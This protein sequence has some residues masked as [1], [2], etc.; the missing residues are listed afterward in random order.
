MF[1]WKDG[2]AEEFKNVTWLTASNVQHA[3][4]F[5]GVIAHVYQNDR[6]WSASIHWRLL[7]FWQSIG[8]ARRKG[9]RAEARNAVIEQ[10][11]PLFTLIA[12]EQD[13]CI[14]IAANDAEEWRK[15]ASASESGREIDHSFE[16]GRLLAATKIEFALRKRK[17]GAR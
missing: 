12:L 1:E 5:Q 2:V 13:A 9:S 6:G 14:A 10:L 11:A 17:D 8:T 3:R 7:R 15:T 4:P 16:L